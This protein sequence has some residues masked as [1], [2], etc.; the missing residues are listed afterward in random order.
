[1][2]NIK[3][4]K[5][6]HKYSSL[7]SLNRTEYELLLSIFDNKVKE[8][9]KHYTLKGRRRSYVS[10]KECKNCS[11]KGSR[12]KLEFM[13]IYL[14]ENPNQCVYGYFY[15]M[16]QSKVSE[17]LSYLLPVLEFSLIELGYT[18]KYGL[19]YTHEDTESE[20]LIGDV[21]ERNVPRRSCHAAQK[22]EYS[23][24]KKRHTHKNFGLT[25][26]QGYVHLISPSYTGSVHD[27][28]IWDDLKIET[29]GQ[30]LFLDLGFLGAEKNRIDV[31]LPFKKPPKKELS[32]VKKQLNKALSSLRVKVE[33][34]FAGIKRLKII[35]NKIRLK[36]YDRRE[37]VMRIAVALHNLRTRLRKSILSNS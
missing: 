17:W 22:E 15:N 2:K 7:T 4:I 21:V 14:K 16:S 19:E 23:G 28:T 8:K 18:A 32:I 27:K 33:H 31:I 12:V 30:N 26:E 36:G 34:A 35:R 13:L 24:K 6:E 37:R 25:D 29:A 20:Y 1:M 5:D 3:P 11:L 10:H 9:L